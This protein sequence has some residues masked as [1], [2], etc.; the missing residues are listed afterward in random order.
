MPARHLE[1]DRPSTGGHTTRWIGGALRES[2]DELVARVRGLSQLCMGLGGDS[3]A[4]GTEGVHF[5]TGTEAV[6]ARRADPA[7]RP[8]DGSDPEFPA[9]G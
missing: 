2:A 4:H 6:T 8:S 3:H 5:C 1:R 7:A 9:N